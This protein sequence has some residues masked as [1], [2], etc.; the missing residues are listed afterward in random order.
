MCINK[1]SQVCSQDHECQHVFLLIDLFCV[2]LKSL[3]LL[4]E[5]IE[6]QVKRKNNKWTIKQLV[7]VSQDSGSAVTF[8]KQDQRKFKFKIKLI[9]QV[10]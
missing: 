3:K 1:V 4:K 7:F 5:Y 8:I 6:W 10:D 9:M 2:Y